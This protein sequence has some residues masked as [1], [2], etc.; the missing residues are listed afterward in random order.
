MK[1]HA[2]IG[3]VLRPEMLEAQM[4]LTWIALKLKMVLRPK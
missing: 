4:K 3:M 1:L 2:E